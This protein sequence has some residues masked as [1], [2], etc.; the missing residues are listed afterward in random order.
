[1]ILVPR[2]VQKR[3]DDA[4][5]L[6]CIGFFSRVLKMNILTNT[7]IEKNRNATAWKMALWSSDIHNSA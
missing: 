1:M 7:Y 4:N 3:W 2:L 5:D 6:K